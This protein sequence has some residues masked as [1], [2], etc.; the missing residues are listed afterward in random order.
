MANGIRES[1]R[2]MLD[3]V[4]KKHYGVELSIQDVL[5]KLKPCMHVKQLEFLNQFY[6]T[7]SNQQVVYEKRFF[8]EN[9]DLKFPI[10]TNIVFN[11][12]KALT[13]GRVRGSVSGSAAIQQNQG[14]FYRICFNSQLF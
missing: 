5:N 14:V 3:H 2:L 6:N 9:T 10:Y 7:N 8:R 4:Y 1:D 12:F 13:G 11:K